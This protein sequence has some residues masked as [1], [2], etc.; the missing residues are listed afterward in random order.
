MGGDAGSKNYCSDRNCS[1]SSELRLAG[2]YRDGE[3]QKR[4]A[5]VSVLSTSVPSASRANEGGISSAG[6]NSV[7]IKFPIRELGAAERERFI[8]EWRQVQTRFVD[9]PKV[10]SAPLMTSHP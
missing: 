4:C 2:R 1:G 3:E 8:T 5:I 10:P 6:A 7:S 9:D